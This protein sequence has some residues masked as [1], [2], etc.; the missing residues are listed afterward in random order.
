MS[1][2]N[3]NSAGSIPQKPKYNAARAYTLTN[4]AFRSKPMGGEG[5][6]AGRAAKRGCGSRIR[7]RRKMLCG[8]LL[9]AWSQGVNMWVMSTLRTEKPREYHIY[10]GA[11]KV[12]EVCF[13]SQAKKWKCY[14]R[15]MHNYV[16]YDVKEHYETMGDAM[17]DLH[18]LLNSPPP[19][20]ATVKG[21]RDAQPKT[22]A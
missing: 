12:A 7:S 13:S 19:E 11:V 16:S 21:D 6:E 1:H 5:S 8:K 3:Y 22:N 20:G 9:G 18:R 17:R 10:I 4:P 15:L 2:E 14:L